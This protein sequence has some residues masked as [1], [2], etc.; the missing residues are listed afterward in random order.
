M[1][2]FG[3]DPEGGEKKRQREK[4]LEI[5]RLRCL[6]QSHCG[7][8]GKPGGWERSR[9]CRSDSAASCGRGE[10]AAA[11][12]LPRLP[13]PGLPVPVKPSL[14][15]KAAATPEPLTRRAGLL[16]SRNPPANKCKEPQLSPLP[17]QGLLQGEQQSCPQPVISP[18]QPEAALLPRSCRKAINSHCHAHLPLP[19]SWAADAS[20]P[21]PHLPRGC[22][23]MPLPPRTG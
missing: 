10:L 13:A 23:P 9:R 14:Q 7:C 8:L 15:E 1:S 4:G 3:W 6:H 22:T 20:S 19:G 5:K 12:A 18:L 11:T 17:P 2:A 16:L 21:T